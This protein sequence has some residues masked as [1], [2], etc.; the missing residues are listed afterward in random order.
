MD[1]DINRIKEVLAEKKRTNKWL[2]AQMGVTDMTVSRWK[3]N[4]IQPSMA[5]FVEISRLLQVDIK[6]LL[7]VDFCSEGLNKA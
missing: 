3:T 6:E 7:E 4:K 1:K 5:Q 2:A